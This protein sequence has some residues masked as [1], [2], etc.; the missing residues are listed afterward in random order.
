VAKQFLR[1][2]QVSKRYN[3]HD[4]TTD[5]MAADGR[6]PKPIYRGKF[7]L[8]D[9]TQLEEFERRAVIDPNPTN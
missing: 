4:R 7:P 1:K 8:W 9:E 2:S 5:R 3:V 6:I